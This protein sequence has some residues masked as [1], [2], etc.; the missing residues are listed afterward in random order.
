VDTAHPSSERTLRAPCGH[1]V[2]RCGVHAS[3]RGWLPGHGGPGRLDTAPGRW[4]RSWPWS[5]DGACAGRRGA[6]A[7]SGDQASS[8]LGWWS[9]T[10]ACCP[11]HRWRSARS[12][13]GLVRV[14]VRSFSATSR[15]ALRAASGRP[16]PGI[17]RLVAG[18]PDSPSTTAP[19]TVARRPV[20]N[21]SRPGARIPQGRHYIGGSW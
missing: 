2:G 12:C 10:P 16:R 1:P 5:W 13:P 4:S 7:S 21:R 14:V 8:G 11:P 20:E 15:P 6:R 19:L 3:H 18:E 17:D 9:G